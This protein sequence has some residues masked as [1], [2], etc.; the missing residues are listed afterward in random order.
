[1]TRTRTTFDVDGIEAVSRTLMR[2]AAAAAVGAPALVVEY[3][4][5]AADLM[6]SM[7]PVDE[8]DV[9]ESITSDT[10]ATATASG[11]FAE[12]GPD[13]EANPEAFVAYWLEDGTALMPPR[14]FVGPAV[15]QVVPDF[16]RAV[17]KLVAGE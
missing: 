3:S 7:V 9:L 10:K 16:Y 1:M 17:E 4:A 5:Y 14:P 13:R 12:S 6:R 15:D 11:V 8:G 2:G